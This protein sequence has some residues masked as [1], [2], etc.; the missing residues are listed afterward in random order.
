MTSEVKIRVSNI[1]LDGQ[2]TTYPNM[3]A[4]IVFAHGSGSSRNSPRNLQVAKALNRAG[5]GTLLFDL[6]TEDEARDRK[7]TFN[8]ELLSHRL[9]GVTLWLKDQVQLKRKPIGYFGASTGAAAALHAAAKFSIHDGVYSVVSRGGRPDLVGEAL[10][11]VRVPTLLLVGSLD[12]DVIELN[13]QSQYQLKNSKLSLIHGATHLFEEPGALAEV[14]KQTI[15]WFTTCLSPQKIQAESKQMDSLEATIENQ[16]IELKRNL[17]LDPLINAIKDKRVVMLGEASH[18]TYEYYQIRRVISQRL[19]Q[20]HGF[21]FIAVE[22]DWPDAYRLH[23]YIQKGEGESARRTLMHNHRW[24]TWMWANEEIVRLAEWMRGH[25][26]GFYGL[27]VYSLFESIDEV[28]HYLRIHAPKLAEEVERQYAC[29]DPYEKD[30]IAYAKSLIQYPGGC[31]NAVLYTLKK[32]LELQLEKTNGNGEE[33]FSSQQN[34]YII[35]NAEDYYR[36]MLM[37]DEQSWNIRDGHMMET[38]NRLLERGG[39][40]AKAI[41]WAHNTHIGDYRATSMR[42]AGYINIGGLARESYGEDN[43]ALIG[44]GSDHGEVLAGSAWGAPEEV[45]PLPPAIPE[46]YEYYFHK[47]AEKRRLNQFYLMFKEKTQTPFA[48]TRGHRAVGV[49]YNP[50][51]ERLGNYVQT[52]LSKRYDAFIYI[53]KTHALKSLHAIPVRGEFPETWPTGQ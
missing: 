5:F 40:S 41:V 29:F 42:E 30:E 7:N 25:K 36:S 1:K 24:P 6:L 19:I 10:S 26:A 2:L 44:F 15:D 35:A 28:T 13:Q 43:V 48:L 27:D 31:K 51:H 21:K 37:G 12:K 23:R 9:F 45:M 20:D 16:L 53:D 17:D 52:E 50:H 4:L 47:V 3:N 32:V 8:V 46:S 22:G 39:E 38:L 33:L 18:G 49:V 11:R 34:A 14:T